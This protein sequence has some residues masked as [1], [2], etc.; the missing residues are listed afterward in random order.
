MF[1]FWSFFFLNE[2]GREFDQ[3]SILCKFAKLNEPMLMFTWHLATLEI[4]WN[5]RIC[6]NLKKN[7]QNWSKS[8]KFQKMKIDAKTTSVKKI[9]VG[10][11]EVS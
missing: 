11:K 9:R 6:I 2:R 3:R 4:S 5:F 7:S 1:G 10:K 8:T